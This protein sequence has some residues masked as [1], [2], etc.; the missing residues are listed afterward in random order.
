[1]FSNM[2][3]EL[4]AQMSVTVKLWSIKTIKQK[5][6]NVWL[7]DLSCLNYSCGKIIFYSKRDLCLNQFNECWRFSEREK[8]N[9]FQIFPIFVRAVTVHLIFVLTKSAK[10]SILSDFWSFSKLLFLPSWLVFRK[11]FQFSTPPPPFQHRDTS[12][13]EGLLLA[14]WNNF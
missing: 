9:N 1:M 10:F 4:S 8:S 11:P 14:N 6:V 2:W 5:S 12:F 7:L 3:K 13:F